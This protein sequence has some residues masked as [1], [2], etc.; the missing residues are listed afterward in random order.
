MAQMN[1][2]NNLSRSLGAAFLLQACTSLI[3]GALFLNP[4]VDSEDIRST[5]LR[6]GSH[7]GLVHASIIGDSITAVGIIFL[8]AML[9]TATE[10]QNKAWSLAALGFYVLEA[11][12]LVVSK[13]AVFVLL[14]MSQDYIATGDQALE[15]LA[16]LALAA[17]DYTYSLHIV[18]FGIGAIIFY[19]LLHISGI[20][21]AWL[22]LW[23]LTAVPFVLVGAAWTIS[24]LPM[25]PA[26][27]ALALPYVP[28][29][30]CAGIYILIQGFRLPSGRKE[31]IA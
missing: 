28:F 21:P 3:S 16:G 22:S 2:R 11:G 17:A 29:E 5:M 15:R 20:V 24:G 6:L 7:P 8:A 25:P 12:I 10:R 14:K 19:C 1:I 18:P 9:Y 13:I 4:L 31:L 23:G 27:L 30:F 26:F